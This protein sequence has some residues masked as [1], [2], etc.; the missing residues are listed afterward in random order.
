MENT[1]Q[2]N[3]A[4]A[5]PNQDNYEYSMI[6]IFDEDGEGWDYEIDYILSNGITGPK[7]DQIA[8]LN[9]I[10]RDIEHYRDYINSLDESDSR[11]DE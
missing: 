3:N 2:E 8:Y 10:I 5:T 1:K 4:M 9:E 11:F 7:K 6:T